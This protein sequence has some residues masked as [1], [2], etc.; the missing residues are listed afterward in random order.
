MM[1]LFIEYSF[2]NSVTSACVL[3]KWLL[4]LKLDSVVNRAWINAAF[5]KFSGF[6]LRMPVNDSAAF[7]NAELQERSM[8]RMNS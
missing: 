2:D 3:K 4:K 6:H 5:R 7:V 8:P 1:I